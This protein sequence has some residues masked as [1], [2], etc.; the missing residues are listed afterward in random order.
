MTLSCYYLAQLFSLF[1]A[2]VQNVQIR[3]R[4]FFRQLSL[5]ANYVFDFSNSNK[6]E[7]L[8][9]DIEASTNLRF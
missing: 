5:N 3:F 8:K 4:E 2:F 7:L 1:V 6:D 9:A